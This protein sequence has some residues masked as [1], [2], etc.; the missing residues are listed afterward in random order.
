M[1]I[2]VRSFE[3]VAAQLGIALVGFFVFRG[4]IQDKESILRFLSILGID[5]AL[6]FFSFQRHP[7]EF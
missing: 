4:K 2:F 5:L 3:I 7:Q 1:D 6:P